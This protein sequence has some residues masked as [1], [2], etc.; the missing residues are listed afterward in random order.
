MNGGDDN[1]NE[2]QWGAGSQNTQA[3]VGHGGDSGF[4]L[5]RMGSHLKVWGRG[6]APPDFD[7][8]RINL[9]ALLT[10]DRRSV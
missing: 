6:A 9:A 1:R 4:T 3:R 7:F 8:K 5:G 2:D 10:T